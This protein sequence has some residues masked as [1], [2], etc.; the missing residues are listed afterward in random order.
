MMLCYQKLKN[1][2]ISDRCGKI[3]FSS[4]TAGGKKHDKKLADEENY[5]FQGRK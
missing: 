1:N 5:E 4:K 2:V 3:L